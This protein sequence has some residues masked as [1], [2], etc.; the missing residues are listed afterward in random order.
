[1]KY[2]SQYNQSSGRDLNPEHPKYE[3]GV[4]ITQPRRPA[5]GYVAWQYGYKEDTV[6][7]PKIDDVTQGYVTLS[8]GL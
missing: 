8:N 1:M 7:K 4:S 3:E 2:L 6:P 5:H